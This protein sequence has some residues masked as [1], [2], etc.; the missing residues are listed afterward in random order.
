MSEILQE[1]PLVRFKLPEQAKRQPVKAGVRAG[2]QPFLDYVNLRGE[3]E[4]AAFLSKVEGTLGVALPVEPNTFTAT[5]KITA[6]WLGP[7]EWLVIAPP[8]QGGDIPRALGNALEEH[9]A[10]VTEVSG[11][12]TTIRLSGERAREL[13]AKGCT[14]DLHPRNFGAGRCVQTL[15]AKA[16]VLLRQSDDAPTFQLIVRR[17][18]ADYLWRWLEEEAEVYGWAVIEH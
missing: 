14:L 2:E 17:S 6:C 13:L 8:E 9:F 15:L 18:F 7:D 5:H 1:S 12:Y 11:G 16:P 3:P 4:D 10:A